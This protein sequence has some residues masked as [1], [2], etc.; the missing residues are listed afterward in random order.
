MFGLI[1]HEECTIFSASFKM[2]T[3]GIAILSLV[4]NEHKNMCFVSPS[5]LMR[6]QLLLNYICP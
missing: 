4:M 3:A 2:T 6:M 5:L 1:K